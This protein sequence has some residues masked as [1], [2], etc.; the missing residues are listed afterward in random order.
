MTTELTTDAE[1]AERFGIDLEKLHI[2]RRRHGWPCVKLGRFDVRF[3]D[4]QVDQILTQMTVEPTKGDDERPKV[5]G[6][7][8]RSASRRRSA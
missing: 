4:A 2:L 8:A 6:Q 7:T 5:P 1:L 3:T